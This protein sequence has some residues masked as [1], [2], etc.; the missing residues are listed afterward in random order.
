MPDPK[1]PAISLND[2]ESKG[3]ELPVRRYST[4]QQKVI[5]ARMTCQDLEHHP[6][7]CGPDLSDPTAGLWVVYLKYVYMP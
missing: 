3:M 4:G 1:P 7:K 5:R 6:F 2:V